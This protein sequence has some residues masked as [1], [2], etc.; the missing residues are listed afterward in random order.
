MEGRMRT[1]VDEIL[2]G[3][4]ERSDRRSYAI[5]GESPIWQ[6]RIL[7]NQIENVENREA[8]WGAA[9]FLIFVPLAVLG[10]VALVRLLG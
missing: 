4:T 2:Y 5:R 3:E 1:V 8:A 6:G 9:A 7:I 10:V